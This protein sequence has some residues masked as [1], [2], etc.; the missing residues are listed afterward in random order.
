[1]K[2]VLATTSPYRIATMKY[3]GIPFEAR[4]S[5]V[6]EYFNNRPTKPV[7][8]VKLL[9]KLKAQAV[10]KDCVDSLVIGMDSV[11]CFQNKIFE[12]P[13]SRDEAFTRLK[14]FSGS[15]HEFYT[16]ITMINTNTKKIYQ[17]CVKTSVKFRKVLDSEIKT[18]LDDDPRFNT[19]ALGYDPLTHISSTF[20][21]EIRGNTYNYLQGI[22]ISRIVEMIH[23]ITGEK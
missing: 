15:S 14:K 7:K 20:I 8:L 3:T 4:G 21:D 2:I 1:M 12:K 19:Y 5:N 23:K 10:A 6:D 9:S 11:G 17:E 16:G 22:P 13:K 18:Y